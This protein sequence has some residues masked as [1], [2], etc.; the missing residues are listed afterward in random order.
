MFVSNLKNRGNFGT[1]RRATHKETGIKYA[2]KFLRRR[3][4]AACWIKQIQHEIAVLMLSANSEQIVK[5][6]AVYETRS[7]FILILEMAAGGELQAILDD[8]S[9]LSEHKARTCVREVLKALEYLHR[10]KIAHLDIKPQNILLNSTNL[11]D[12]LKLCDFGFARAIEGTKNVCEIQGTP[13]YVAP[14]I[15]QYE[16]LSLK[17]DIWS[18]GVLTYVLLTGF[19]PFGGDDKHETFLN[20]TQCNLTFPEDLFGNVSDEAIDFMKRTMRLKPCDRLDVFECMKHKWLADDTT[21]HLTDP[22]QDIL[23]LQLADVNAMNFPTDVECL[24]SSEH[25]KR[26]ETTEAVDENKENSI[27][28]ADNET[29]TTTTTLNCHQIS[30]KMVLEK[31][32]TISLFPDAPTT[33]K[34]CRKMLYED[35]DDLNTQVK[36]IV[37]KYQTNDNQQQKS[38]STCCEDENTGECLLCKSTKTKPPSLELDTGIVC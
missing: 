22:P 38:S 14:E 18:V 15:V 7:E 34:V 25:L 1:V 30:S 33:P 26:D 35:E 10:R 3:R 5:L 12:G 37:K 24:K 4:R 13:D 16:P 23:A 31:S 6:H 9:S 20:I 2:A 19:S 21:K 29:T 32:L 11:E 17:T 27:R 36:E 8:D 28:S